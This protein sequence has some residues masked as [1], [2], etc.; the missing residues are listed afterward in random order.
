MGVLNINGG[1]FIQ[2][3]I[4]T[5]ATVPVGIG[6]GR[7]GIMNLNGGTFST[8]SHIQMGGLYALTLA[9]GVQ[10]YGEINM[11]SGTFV[12]TNATGT[13]VLNVGSGVA[14]GRVNLAGGTMTVDGLL[15]DKGGFSEINFDGG[16]LTVVK[17]A[18]VDNGAAMVVG[19]GTTA[20]TFNLAG[21]GVASF[22]DGLVVNT[23]ATLMAGG[24][25]AIGAVALDGDL[26]LRS[27]AILDV[28]FNATTNDFLQVAGTVQLPERGTLVTR[29]LDG[30]GRREIPLI[31]AT[32]LAGTP[33]HWTSVA[34]SGKRY[35]LVVSD[36][37]LLLERI[38]ETTL[39]QIR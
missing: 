39:I 29:S 13:A 4:G 38:P 36:N 15:A 14:L 26:T 6:T 35:R 3:P 1:T 30:A 16:A 11:N 32:L 31:Q 20:A 5:H 19:D 7:V 2:N 9:V 24:P 28:D 33:A 18:E 23:N 25:G 8:T 17:S 12:A 22:A 27:G 21:G 34:V 10:R 37:V